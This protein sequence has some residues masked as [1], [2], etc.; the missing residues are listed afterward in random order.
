MEPLLFIL[1][2]VASV[3]FVFTGI[4]LDSPAMA[5]GAFCAMLFLVLA[6]AAGVI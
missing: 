5:I 2:F 4:E 6:V 3:G 1:L